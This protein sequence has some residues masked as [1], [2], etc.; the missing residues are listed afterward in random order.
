MAQ[1]IP[2]RT[3]AIAFARKAGEKIGKI[4]EDGKAHRINDVLKE[5]AEHCHTI[6]DDLASPLSTMIAKGRV[7]ADMVKGTVRKPGSKD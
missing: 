1:Q 6:A 5:A 4:L 7:V 3:E 2:S